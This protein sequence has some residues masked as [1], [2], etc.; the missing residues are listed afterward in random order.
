LKNYIRRLSNELDVSSMP[1]F[2]CFDQFKK[3]L[4]G[5][6]ILC[7]KDHSNCNYSRK[8]WSEK[9]KCYVRAII[10]PITKIIWSKDL[11]RMFFHALW[12]TVLTSKSRSWNKPA[13]IQTGPI[14]PGRFNVS[15][16]R[17]E[18][19]QPTTYRDNQATQDKITSPCSEQPET[20]DINEL[21]YVME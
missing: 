13:S 16:T 21:K 7:V 14:Q 2:L 1:S 9:V 3:I 10:Q 11:N 17:T 19:R 8:E 20:I 18:S 4:H 5:K 6:C 12:G 15:V